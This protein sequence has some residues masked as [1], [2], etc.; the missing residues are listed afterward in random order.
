MV[1][2][3]ATRKMDEIMPTVRTIRAGR[4]RGGSPEN[5][6]VVSVRTTTQKQSG[7]D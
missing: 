2:G 4:V 7:I 6:R 1:T 3:N 5:P